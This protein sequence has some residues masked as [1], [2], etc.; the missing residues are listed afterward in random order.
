MGEGKLRIRPEFAQSLG[1]G[2]AAPPGGNDEY[3][4][5]LCPIPWAGNLRPQQTTAEAVNG[6]ARPCPGVQTGDQLPKAS[7]GQRIPQAEAPI[8]GGFSRGRRATE[9]AY[10]KLACQAGFGISF[11]DLLTPQWSPVQ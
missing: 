9:L 2:C 5:E 10:T 3:R 8:D 6:A 4:C 7:L 1:S 11:Y